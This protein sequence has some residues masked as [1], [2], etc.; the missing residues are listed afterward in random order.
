M[1]RLHL[2]PSSSSIF[3]SQPPGAVAKPRPCD[4]FC[5]R[6]GAHRRLN[7]RPRPWIRW[8]TPPMSPAHLSPWAVYPPTAHPR[9]YPHSLG[10][11]ISL[12][13][14]SRSYAN[15]SSSPLPALPFDDHSPEPPSSAAC[16]H[17]M[18]CETEPKKAGHLLDDHSQKLPI[19]TR[20]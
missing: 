17:P 10:T 13:S 1:I 6:L 18:R 12:T 16:M 8:W 19:L 20:D 3:C 15:S 7:P 4:S 9:P 14:A 11:I 5:R 2:A